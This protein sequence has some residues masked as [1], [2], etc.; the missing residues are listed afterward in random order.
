MIK[1]QLLQHINQKYH[2]TINMSGQLQFHLHDS[3]ISDDC[4]S[5]AEIKVIST[6]KT[7]PRSKSLN[8]STKPSQNNTV[9]EETASVSL[10]I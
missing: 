3:G 4:E 2:Q 10:I 1:K 9:S 6:P 7:S 8:K 5:D